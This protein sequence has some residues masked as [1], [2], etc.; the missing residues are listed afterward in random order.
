M[1]GITH[2]S[3]KFPWLILAMAVCCGG[4]MHANAYQAEGGFCVKTFLIACAIE[5]VA[6]CLLWW[7]VLAPL[8]AWGFFIFHGYKVMQKSK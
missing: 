2:C 1:D 5:I 6:Y 8:A 7:T 4:S 3:T